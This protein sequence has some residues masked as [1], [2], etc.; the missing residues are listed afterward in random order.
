[1]R[2][3]LVPLLFLLAGL[4]LA[5]TEVVLQDGK[6]MQVTDVRRDG[7]QTFRQYGHFARRLVVPLVGSRTSV[8][9]RNWK[10]TSSAAS[11]SL[12]TLIS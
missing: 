4:A 2:H 9:K 12:S 7:D 1:M 11:L 3:T 10:V 6:V 5:G 8:R